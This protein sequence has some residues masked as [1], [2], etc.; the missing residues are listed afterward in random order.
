[1]ADKVVNVEP[2]SRATIFKQS[3]RGISVS[4]RDVGEAKVVAW[5]QW[6]MRDEHF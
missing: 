2:T 5:N 3:S 1:V 4:L 6:G